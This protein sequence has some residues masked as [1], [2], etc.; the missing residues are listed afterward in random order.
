MQ[1]GSIIFRSAV[2][3]DSAPVAELHA[4]SWQSAYRGFLSD[5]YLRQGHA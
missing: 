3:S 2:S 1:P 4:A 5:T